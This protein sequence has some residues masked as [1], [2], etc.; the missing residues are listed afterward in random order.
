LSF[1]LEQRLKEANEHASDAKQ[2]E[3]CAKIDAWVNN[4][5]EPVPGFAAA[6]DQL[7]ELSYAEYVPRKKAAA[8]RLNVPTKD[9]DRLIE[10][11]RPRVDTDIEQGEFIDLTPVEPW[12]APVDG[13]VL[14]DDLSTLFKRYIYFVE[15]RIADSIALWTLGTYCFN[16]FSL[17]PFLGISAAAENSGKTTLAKCV[18]R[19]ACRALSTSNVTPAAVFRLI[20]MHQCTLVID[21]MDTF[22]KPDSELYGILNSGHDREMAHVIRTVGDEHEPRVFSTWCPRVWAMIGLPKPTITSRSLVIRLLRKPMELELELLP[23]LLHLGEEWN[24]LQRQCARWV[25]DH[26][27]EIAKTSSSTVGLANREADNWEPL[28]TIAI[29]AGWL[30]RA[31]AAAGLSMTVINTEDLNIILL[32]DIRNI[33]HTRKIKRL[34]SMVLTQDLNAQTESPWPTYRGTE[35]SSAIQLTAHALGDLLGKV[36]VKSFV[37]KI[38]KNEPTFGFA[39]GRPIRGYNLDQFKDLF[40][41]YLGDEPPLEVVVTQTFAF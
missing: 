35:K 18:R 25:K 10:E 23:K 39:I 17:Y 33:F 12:E 40:A 32:R 22:L 2:V 29:V 19:L 4:E 30:E 26:H 9:L 8:K 16:D 36:H 1:D 21:E 41:S 37:F 14:L 11:K 27:E 28:F 38:T 34:P 6:V 7:A 15:P 13:I 3:A 5:Q 31:R 24:R 20:A